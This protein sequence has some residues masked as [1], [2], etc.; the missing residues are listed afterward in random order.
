MCELAVNE[1]RV[2]EELGQAPQCITLHPGFIPICLTP[3][4]LEMLADQFKTKQNK[5]Y[6]SLGS[7]NKFL[8]AV[9]FRAFTRL[10]H[11]KIGARRVPLPAC[12]Y[13]A[14]RNK[15]VVRHEAATGYA[16]E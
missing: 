15:F 4:T 5:R 7:E 3:W 10:V 12:A 16:D 6:K 9:A 13:H 1:F 2:V 14:I 11:G 8:R